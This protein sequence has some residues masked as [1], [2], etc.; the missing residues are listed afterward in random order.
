MSCDSVLLSAIDTLLVSLLL[1]FFSDV[2]FNLSTVGS[3]LY[4]GLEA[5]LSPP[6]MT[7]TVTSSMFL[8]WPRHCKYRLCHYNYRLCHHCT[9]NPTADSIG[10]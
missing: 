1:V 2:S 10:P 5:L 7:H 3:A 6:N 8:Q 4:I 9:R